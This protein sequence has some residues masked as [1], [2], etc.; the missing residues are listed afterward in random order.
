[1]LTP[2]M[3]RNLFLMERE[4]TCFF[5]QER[6]HSVHLAH[7]QALPVDKLRHKESLPHLLKRD[8]NLCSKS[9][10]WNLLTN[11]FVSF[12]NNLT[13]NDWNWRTSITNLLNLEEN[14]YACKKNI[15]LKENALRQAQKRNSHELGEMK[16]ARELRVD[17]FSVQTLRGKS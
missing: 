8:L 14:N 13:L 6:E 12:S 2:R 11:V 3:L 10:K 17:E 15:S 1:M 4:I 16:R 7:L 5:K 9:T